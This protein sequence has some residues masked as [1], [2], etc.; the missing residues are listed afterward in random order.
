MSILEDTYQ[1]CLNI[2]KEFKNKKILF[3]P[4]ES[5][6][7]PGISII[8]GLHELG[9]EI[10][11]YKKSNIN[12]WFCNKIIDSLDNIEDNI[13]FVL[14]NI[15]WGT[16]WS[17]YN[18]LNHKVPYV[19]IDGEDRLHEYSKHEYWKRSSWLD[20]IDC[21]KKNYKNN[22]PQ[23]IK[24]MEQSPYR[25]VEDIGNYKPDIIF[26]SQKYKINTKEIYLPF[27]IKKFYFKNQIN[28]LIENRN[29][30][31]IHLDSKCDGNYR[32]KTIEFIDKYKTNSNYNI[33][34]GM[35]YGNVECDKKIEK[36][37]KNDKNVHSWHRWR[38]CDKYFE[39]LNNSK[40]LVY[41]SVDKYNAPGWE[42]KR[43][44]ET[45]SQGCLMVYQMQNDFDNAS[46]PICE[47][48]NEFKF[49]LDNYD[50]M[51]TKIETHLNNLELLEAKRID[52]TEKFK[53]YFQSISIARYFLWNIKN[54]YNNN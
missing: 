28:K 3:I 15:H 8:E 1:K 43:P 18:K 52:I 38:Y 14:S 54:K 40:I 47:L 9:F 36:Y 42:S 16:Q 23:K 49:E 46:Y 22:P 53:K 6:D 48:L 26:K 41:P 27:G 5:Y 39:E 35:V 13:D 34:N 29:I 44:Y 12:S 17:L 10:L 32:K 30:D 7:D 50:E 45:L 11:T 51:M 31:I 19:L 21:R 33:I 25:W 37:V 24:D 2:E 4:T 20:T